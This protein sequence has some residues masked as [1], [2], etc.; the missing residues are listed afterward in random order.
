M[1]RRQGLV[2]CSRGLVPL[3]VPRLEPAHT[4]TGAGCE[5]GRAPGLGLVLTAQQR[6][7]ARL[8][9]RRN[10]VCE[11]GMEASH[12]G[13]EPPRGAAHPPFVA[14]GGLDHPQQRARRTRHGGDDEHEV[15]PEDGCERP[16]S[17]HSPAR[18]G[19][20]CHGCGHCS[21]RG[22]SC[23]CSCYSTMRASEHVHMSWHARAGWRSAVGFAA[24]VA[25]GFAAVGADTAVA[26]KSGACEHFK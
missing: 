24:A 2:V 25:G 21:C 11:P 20:S 22:C 3:P 5:K 1:Q 12:T 16:C 13:A 17:P 7:W 10:Q 19:S 6:E 15:G 4:R 18:S 8:C 23:R 14:Q 9:P 26:N